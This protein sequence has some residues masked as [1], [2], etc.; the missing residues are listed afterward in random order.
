MSLK[1]VK[2]VSHVGVKMNQCNTPAAV[3]HVGQINNNR[4]KKNKK[5]GK[6]ILRE[7]S[8]MIFHSLAFARSRGKC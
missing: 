7:E 8:N 6:H 1:G 4:R 5:E 3:R 2:T